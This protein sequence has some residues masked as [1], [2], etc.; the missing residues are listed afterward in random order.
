MPTSNPRINVTLEK[1]IYES[2]K[3]LAK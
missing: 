3:R 2:V 1:P